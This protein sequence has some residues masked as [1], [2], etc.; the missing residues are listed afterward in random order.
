MQGDY[1]EKWYVKLLTITSII[2][3]KCILPLLFASPSY[4][5]HSMRHVKR[6]VLESDSLNFVSGSTDSSL[7]YVCGCNGL[8]RKSKWSSSG[9]YVHDSAEYIIKSWRKLAQYTCPL[10]GGQPHLQTVLRT[11]PPKQ[12]MRNS[13]GGGGKLPRLDNCTAASLMI[14]FLWD[15]LFGW[16]S[17]SWRFKGSCAFIT[18]R[19]LSIFMPLGPKDEGITLFQMSGTTCPVTQCH[20]QEDLYICSESL[21]FPTA[22]SDYRQPVNLLKPTGYVTHQQFNIQQLYVLPTLYLCVLHL[23]QNKQR[24]VPLTP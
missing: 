18:G 10:D 14:R 12:R 17:T 2:A 20:V 8:L 4:S 11:Q 7:Q 23:S 16:L 19:S 1:V 6:V 9:G 13:K 5:R 22:Q 21:W 15:V 24:L 3:I